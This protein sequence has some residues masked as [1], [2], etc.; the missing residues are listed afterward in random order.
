MFASLNQLLKPQVFHCR[1]VLFR[2]CPSNGC[3]VTIK[4]STSCVAVR[5]AGSRAVK[6]TGKDPASLV[7]GTARSVQLPSPSLPSW[8]FESGSRTGLEEW[9]V[10][11]RVEAGNRVSVTVNGRIENVPK[12]IAQVLG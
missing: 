5:P 8:R 12:G 6:V 2:V 4:T 11:V 9:T 3:G 1:F 7:A 10:T